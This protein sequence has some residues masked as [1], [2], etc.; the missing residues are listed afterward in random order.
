MT[1]WVTVSFSRRGSLHEQIH[2]VQILIEKV[3]FVLIPLSFSQSQYKEVAIWNMSHSITWSATYLSHRQSHYK[4]L[5]CCQWD[6]GPRKWFLSSLHASLLPVPCPR[7]G[8]SPHICN[9]TMCFWCTVLMGIMQQEVSSTKV[10]INFFSLIFI[11][12]FSSN[13]INKM[14]VWIMF[15]VLWYM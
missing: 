15:S 1:S 9:T 2:T 6:C 11:R 12:F 4:K 10:R 8:L 7:Q 13:L 3:T 14:K 5:N